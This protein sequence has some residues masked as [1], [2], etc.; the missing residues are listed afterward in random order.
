V[1]TFGIVF[2]AVLF[3]KH[4]CFEQV[5]EDFSVQE[6]VPERAVEAFDVAVFPGRIRRDKPSHDVKV[7]QMAPDRVD[8]T[9][10]PVVAA[11]VGRRSVMI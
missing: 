8:D 9:L 2:L 4:F 1:W 7:R 10:W 5:T 3:A 11:D 6:F